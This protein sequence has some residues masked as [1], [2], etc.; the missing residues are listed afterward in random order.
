MLIE[1]VEQRVDGLLRKLDRGKNDI[2]Y[3]NNQSNKLL[4]KISVNN[5]KLSLWLE[6]TRLF[7]ILFSS[8]NP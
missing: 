4:D 3:I 2:R 7:E 5:T 6:Q 8:D 1:F